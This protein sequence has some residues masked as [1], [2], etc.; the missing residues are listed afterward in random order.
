[1][2]VQSPGSRDDSEGAELYNNLNSNFFHA[3]DDDFSSDDAEDS[4]LTECADQEANA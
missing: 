1:M 2:T 4:N 3:V